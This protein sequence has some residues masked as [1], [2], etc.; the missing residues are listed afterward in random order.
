M[1]LNT[2]KLAA[3]SELSVKNGSELL[4]RLVK[5]IVSES[6]STY[7]SVL[8][9]PEEASQNLKSSKESIASSA[10]LTTAFDLARFIPLLKERIH[11]MNPFTRTFLVLWINLLDSIPDLELV[12]YLPAF[13]GGLIKFLNDGNKDVYVATQGVLEQ[14]LNEIK[15][16][17]RIQRGIAESRREHGDEGPRVSNSS[18]S[19][20]LRTDRSLNEKSDVVDGEDGVLQEEKSG[21]GDD[22]WVPGQ[23]VQVDHSKILEIL[24]AFLDPDSGKNCL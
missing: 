6:A 5:D 20:S 21:Q 7:V 15:K 23:D 16:V 24:V 12:H 13:L 2:T 14:F 19:A 22:D 11:V 3:D 4:D 1:V 17:A 9:S 10:S 18:D 8:Q